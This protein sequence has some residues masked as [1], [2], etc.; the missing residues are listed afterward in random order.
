MKGTCVLLRLNFW[1]SSVLQC[2]LEVLDKMR[3]SVFSVL[4]KLQL[5]WPSETKKK[6]V[7]RGQAERGLETRPS[8]SVQIP[9]VTQKC[10]LARGGLTQTSPTL[11]FLLPSRVS[12]AGVRQCIP[13]RSPARA[14]SSRGADSPSAP[15]PPPTFLA[16]LCLIPVSK[17][18]L[19]P[20]LFLCTPGT[21][22]YGGGATPSL[23]IE[24][25]I[26][27]LVSY[28]HEVFAIAACVFVPV[29]ACV[30][31]LSFA[32]NF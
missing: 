1:F 21:E 5:K 4:Q 27:H 26:F 6:Q 25:V 12:P 8:A 19:F 15:L 2:H 3:V 22:L 18:R 31:L 13:G 20:P 32:S 23:S 28:R 9:M 29:C 7:W 30:S 14:V 11:S 24:R 10:G 16:W 17:V